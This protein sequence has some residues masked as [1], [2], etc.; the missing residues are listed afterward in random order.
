MCACHS[1]ELRVIIPTI[2]VIKKR[3]CLLGA[4]GVGK[5]SLVRHF[6]HS[7]F[8][9]KYHSTIGVK[10]DKKVVVVGE[11]EV[12]MMLWDIAGEEEF[13]QIPES[14]V[15]GASGCL[16]VADGTRPETVET[17]KAIRQRI[18]GKLGENLPNTILI[19]KSDLAEEWK[20]T[21]DTRIALEADGT[22]CLV[23][24]AKTGAC[25]EEGF[26]HLAERMV[27]GY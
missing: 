27:T 5:T 17:L 24:S 18:F 3:V 13:F 8:D 4:F 14:Y 22:R 6:V 10:V 2:A 16:F 26:A 15:S 9:E 1:N 25:V 20:L 11:E 23:T 12:T 19:N 7:I 21:D